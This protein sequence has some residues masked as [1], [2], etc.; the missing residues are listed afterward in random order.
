M[1]FYIFPQEIKLKVDKRRKGGGRFFKMVSL[2]MIFKMTS[3]KNST[4]SYKPKSLL[5]ILG[6]ISL[7][8][9]D[10]YKP[11]SSKFLILAKR[12]EKPVPG[13]RMTFLL[14][15]MTGLNKYWYHCILIHRIQELFISAVEITDTVL[16]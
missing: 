2:M 9:C 8:Y 5:F 3:S 7:T 13:E 15:L 6:S 16:Y 10:F 14:R 4:R 11:T 12:S 1:L